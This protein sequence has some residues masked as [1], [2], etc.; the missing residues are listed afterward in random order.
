MKTDLAASNPGV[1]QW[2]GPWL[3]AFLCAAV[4][5]GCS[6]LDPQTA[7]LP[8]FHESHRADLVVQFYSWDLFHVLRPEYRENGF[9][10]PVSRT[11]FTPHLQR[12]RT[13]RTLAVVVV[14]VNYSPE[15]QTRL[16]RE[17]EALLSENGF[18]RCVCLRGNGAQKIDGLIILGDTHLTPHKPSTH[19]VSKGP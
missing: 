6:S 9:L 3:T 2:M 8:R 12:L 5:T 10:V 13:G 18:E 15:E 4:C 17:W 1:P 19:M 14:G 16:I 7:H 11:T